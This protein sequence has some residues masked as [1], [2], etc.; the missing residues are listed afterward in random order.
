VCRPPQT[1][2]LFSA[3]AALEAAEAKPQSTGIL[4]LANKQLQLAIQRGQ[5]VGLR[6]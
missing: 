2:Y 3:K 5:Q 1:A 6:A 4:G